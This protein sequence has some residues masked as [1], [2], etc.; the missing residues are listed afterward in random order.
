MFSDVEKNLFRTLSSSSKKNQDEILRKSIDSDFDEIACRARIQA[1]PNEIPILLNHIEESSEIAKG[2]NNMEKFLEENMGLVFDCLKNFKG[3][4]SDIEDLIQE[5]A[6]ALM[7]A[8]EKFDPSKKFKFSTY[9]EKCISRAIARY[10]DKHSRNV[11]IPENIYELYAKIHKFQSE[12]YLMYGSEPT[13]SEIAEVLD[14]SEHS[15]ERAITALSTSE[16]SLDYQLDQNDSE[17]ITFV[18]TYMLNEYAN[19]EEELCK[20]YMRED[21]LAVL[22][23]LENEDQIKVLS[24]RFGFNED[25]EIL[26]HKEIGEKMGFSKQRSHQLEKAGLKKLSSEKNIRKLNGYL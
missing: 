5:G 14:A 15:I 26:G 10:I 16:Y 7:D 20:K 18:D 11:R 8:K 12:Y 13:V 6:I 4:Y 9:A 24:D 25:G 3:Q 21:S 19:P 22:N 1:R 17:S 23:S 2:G